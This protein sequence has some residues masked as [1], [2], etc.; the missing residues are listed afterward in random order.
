MADKNLLAILELGDE[1]H[2]LIRDFLQ[3]LPDKAIKIFDSVG[4]V[5]DLKENLRRFRREDMRHFAIFRS[6]TFDDLVTEYFSA[7]P[8]AALTEIPDRL[9][10]KLSYKQQDTD[11]LTG[12]RAIF[13]FDGSID[14]MID[15]YRNL[16]STDPR[17]LLLDYLN[18]SEVLRKNITKKTLFGLGK[19]KIVPTYVLVGIETS[20]GRYLLE[21]T[22]SQ[23]PYAGTSRK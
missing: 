22:G 19:T 16:S 17:K 12:A 8:E 23:G 21:T 14:E 11:F 5:G 1:T 7:I 2:Y 15:K 10:I 3:S 13:T 9:K 18:Q 6:P 4:F 20:D